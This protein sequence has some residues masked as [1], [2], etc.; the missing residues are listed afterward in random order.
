V[1]LNKSGW[2]LNP[3]NATLISTAAKA[4][5]SDEVL[6]K[7]DWTTFP[8]QLCKIAQWEAPFAE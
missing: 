1:Q 6:L 8:D 3:S 2:K 5:N 7:T 4:K